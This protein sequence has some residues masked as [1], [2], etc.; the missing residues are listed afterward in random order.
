MIM[1]RI[2]YIMID[3]SLGNGALIFIWIIHKP[4]RSK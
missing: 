1:H 4:T 3:F 2:Y